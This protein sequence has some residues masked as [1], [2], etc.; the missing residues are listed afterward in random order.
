[1]A[2]E[3]HYLWDSCV[4]IAYLC[5]ER[6]AYDI[7]SIKSHLEDAKQ[8]RTQIHVSTIAA[9]EVLPSRLR[10]PS[11][12]NEF[13]DDLTGAVV[14]FDPSPNIMRLAGQLRDLPY[15]GQDGKRRSLST[16]D[17]IMLATAVHLQEEWNVN[18]SAIHSFDKNGRKD[19]NGDKTV[20]ILGYENFCL[21]FDPHQMA[22]AARVI[23][24]KRCAPLHPRP[25]LPNF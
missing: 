19:F 3:H 17:A 16:P 21:G 20:P 9:A 8:G 5:D 13:M 1:M 7:E 4:F 2:V 18:L 14:F 15:A 11:S 10:P 25:K 23:R 12:F 22:T 6:H 24:I